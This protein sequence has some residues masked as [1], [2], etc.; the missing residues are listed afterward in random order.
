MRCLEQEDGA[1]HRGRDQ[2]EQARVGDRPQQQ[3]VATISQLQ[4]TTWRPTRS[5]DATTGSIGTSTFA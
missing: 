2:V 3:R 4:T 5:A 1:E